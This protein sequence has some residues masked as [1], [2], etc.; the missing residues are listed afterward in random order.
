MQDS[1]SDPLLPPVSK[2][3]TKDAAPTTIPAPT[4]EITTPPPQRERRRR[5][6]WFKRCCAVGKRRCYACCVDCLKI[7]ALDPSV[8]LVMLGVCTGASI[9]LV[10][11]GCW[12]THG[13]LPIV[14]VAMNFAA[15]FVFFNGGL[16]AKVRQR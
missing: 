8:L 11:V 6:G 1:P 13:Y 15:L 10:L 9:F 16:Y 2:P 5:P 12:L 7:V 14:C 3:D 4:A